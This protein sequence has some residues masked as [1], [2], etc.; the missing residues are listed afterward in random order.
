MQISRNKN[1]L[2]SVKISEKIVNFESKIASF[3][4]DV[5]DV[6]RLVALTFTWIDDCHLSH[7]HWTL[8]SVIC[9]FLN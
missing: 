5:A 4:S 8:A 7:I 2:L 9:A 1:L 3:R 6:S